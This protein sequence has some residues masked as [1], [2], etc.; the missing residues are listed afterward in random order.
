MSGQL[1][2]HVSTTATYLLH[3]IQDVADAV[4]PGSTAHPTQEQYTRGGSSLYHCC[5]HYRPPNLCD[6][7]RKKDHVQRTRIN[8]GWIT[9][10]DGVEGN[11][12]ADAEAKKVIQEG[13]S[14][15]SMLPELLQNEELP[16]SITAAGLTFRTE[17]LTSWRS[18]W[19]GS[20]RQKRMAKIDTKLPSASFLRATDSM[21][22]AQASIRMQL[23][24]GHAPLQR[25][26][27]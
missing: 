13:S 2:F 9:G 18:L 21:T 5:W 27:H 15:H 19:K 12:R 11:E 7:W 4:D 14:P 20:P 16:R 1:V 24:T 10:H 17:V 3:Q 26:L 23:R 8:I 6:E 22:R 25:F